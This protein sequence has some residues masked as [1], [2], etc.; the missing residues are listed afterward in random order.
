MSQQ[1][2]IFRAVGDYVRTEKGEHA[3]VLSTDLRR[4]TCDILIGLF[5][6]G[7]RAIVSWW[8]LKMPSDDTPRNVMLGA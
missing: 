5:G 2:M 1:S 8:D 4:N 3:I 7:R 6:E